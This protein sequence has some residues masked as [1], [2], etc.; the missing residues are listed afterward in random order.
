MRFSSIMARVAPNTIFSLNLFLIGLGST[1]AQGFA[2]GTGSALAREA[3]GS[4]F[5]GGS[6]SSSAPAAA[7]APATA[8]PAPT[9]SY[10]AGPC[11]VDQKA[12]QS[13]LQQ[14]PNNASVCDHYFTALQACQS[15]Y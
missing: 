5:G 12:F 14:N 13:C 15:R 3:V 10:T 1:M 9:P 7:P 11:E 6:S 2:F 4:I 8:A